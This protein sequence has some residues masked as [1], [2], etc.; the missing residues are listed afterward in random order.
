MTEADEAARRD[1]TRRDA[2][3]DQLAGAGMDPAIAER[4]CAAWEAEATLRGVR[5]DDDFWEAGRSW[6]DGQCAARRQPP[7]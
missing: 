4:W 6:I 1:R 7:N 3:R 5:R 2:I